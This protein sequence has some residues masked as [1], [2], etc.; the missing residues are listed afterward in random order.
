M[1]LAEAK[2]IMEMVL[3]PDS[4]DY[5]K[6]KTMKKEIALGALSVRART[7]EAKLR[8]APVDKLTKLFK[9]L[10]EERK[11]MGEGAKVIEGESRPREP[12]RH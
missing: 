5:I 3:D 12:V 9:Q 2:A 4:K 8:A 1:A 11:A 10:E 7:D 6:L